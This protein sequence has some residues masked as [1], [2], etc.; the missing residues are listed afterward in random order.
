M[1]TSNYNAWLFYKRNTIKPH[2][3][4]EMERLPW[5]TNQKAL[6]WTTYHLSCLAP[7]QCQ[8]GGMGT[9]QHALYEGIKAQEGKT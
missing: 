8:V 3:K 2:E 9:G 1:A 4:T 7:G 6:N 5:L